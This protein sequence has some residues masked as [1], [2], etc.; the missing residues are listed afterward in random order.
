[1]SGINLLWFR[2]FFFFVFARFESN[3]YLCVLMMKMS[4]HKV[5]ILWIPDIYRESDIVVPE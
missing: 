2:T 5:T 3:T 4:L 1:M